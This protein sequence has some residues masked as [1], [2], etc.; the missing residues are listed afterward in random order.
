MLS[1]LGAFI[2]S[3][4]EGIMNNFFREINFIYIT[5]V[6]S[7]DSDSLFKKKI[8]WDALEKTGL[9]GDDLY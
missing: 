3:N 5:N 4:S 6:F 8:Y 1:H 2:L 7:S 9:V